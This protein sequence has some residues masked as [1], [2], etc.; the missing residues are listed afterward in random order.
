MTHNG[1]ELLRRL[2]VDVLDGRY[3]A[4]APVGSSFGGAAFKGVDQVSGQ[5]VFM[6]YL[7]SPR[8]DHERAKFLL[9]AQVLQDLEKW[10]HRVSPRLIHFAHPSDID[11][12]A[13]VL[14][15]IEGEMLTEYLARAPHIPLEE[16]IETFHRIVR[17]AS[18]ATLPYQHRDI[19]P[20]N[21]LL[22][23]RESARIGPETLE[24]DVYSA[25]KILDW[26]EALPHIFGSY[27]AEPDHHFVLYERA[28]V[29][30]SGSFT[31]L[32]P[33]IFTRWQVAQG[34]GGT[35]EVWGLGLL[36][37]SLMTGKPP[38][39]HRGLGEY[40][41]AIQTGELREWIDGAHQE[42]CTLD[43]PGG[44]ILPRIWKRM[45]SIS[46]VERCE[47]STVGRILWDIRYEALALPDGFRL[48]AYMAN[49]NAYQPEGGWTYSSIPDFD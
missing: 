47:L 48:D 18:S 49:P 17:A 23:S 45:L 1:L 6:K 4:E 25:V 11:V 41:E 30:I 40:I 43:L 46:R 35:Y 3:K 9:E 22:E 28:P 19:H 5:P 32:P 44:S 8:G 12:L 29:T 21:I 14:E 31:N 20:G 27:D 42:L 26:G 15:W 24:R 39:K 13:L 33:E 10:Q 34:L 37:Y 7:V 16:R 36:F 38:I 2:G